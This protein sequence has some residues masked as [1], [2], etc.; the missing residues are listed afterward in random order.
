[1]SDPE[2]VA[3]YRA[4]W[5]LDKPLM[6]Q[7]FIYLGNLLRGDLGVSIRTGNPVLSDLKQFFPATLELSIV[8][9]IIA[10]LFG[11]TFG[12]LSAVYRNKSVDY[13]VRTISISGVSIPNFWFALV[14]LLLFYSKWHLFPGGG[15]I[16]SRMTAPTGGT[17]L[18]VLDGILQGDWALVNDALS[19][20]ILPAIVLG[21]F[22]MGLIS[23]QTRSNLL[24]VTS[25]DYIRTA[26]AKGLSRGRIIMR[27]ALGNALIPVIT[28]MGMGFSNLLGG[29][30]FVEKIFSWPGIGQYAYLS[31]TTL[32][33]PAICGVSLLIA[34]VNVILNLLIDIL[35]GVIDPRVRYS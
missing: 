14:M 31:A 27:H 28:V 12:V 33:F 2:A 7:Y 20:L 6:Q 15:R 24:E 34:M 32:D 23:R 17:G 13:A 25:L 1:M 22:T 9:M 29:M 3:A 4:R 30:V 11:I 16:N 5:G 26:K 35:Y 18:Y 8:A 21:F 10:I 19:H